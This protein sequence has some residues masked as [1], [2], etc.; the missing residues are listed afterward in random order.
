MAI[1]EMKKLSLVAMAYDQDAILN[2]LHQTNAVQITLHQD[3]EQTTAPSVDAEELQLYLASVDAAL[4]AL[5]TEIENFNKENNIKSDVL[6]DGFEV[7][8]DDFIVMGEKRAEMDEVLRRINGLV[9][10]KNTLKNEIVKALKHIQGSKIYA[11]L[12]QP[13]A[14]FVSTAKT[15]IR[16]GVVAFTALENLK[17]QLDEM[18]L[19]DYQIL[20]TQGEDAL[21][22]VMAHKSIS[23]ETDGVLSTYGF[24]DHAFDSEKSGAQ[25]Y[26]EYCDELRVKQSALTQNAQALYALKSHVHD[27][28]VY[29]EY[30]AFE[31]E[32]QLSQNKMRQ[33]DKTFFLQAY[34]PQLA[35]EQVKQAIQSVS[36][37]AYIQ[38]TE[39][40]ETDEPPTLL[41]NN[42]IVS[43]FESITNMYSAPNYREFDP[44]SVMA[45]FYSVFMGFIIGDAG[46]GLLMALIGGYLWLSNRKNP[47]GMSRLAGAFA[48]GG[49]FAIVWGM[50]FNS[51][52]GVAV[53]PTT[54]MPDP[55][56]GRCSFIGIQVPSVLIISLVVGISQLCVGYI[57]KA[58]QCFRRGQIADGI[59][60][61]IL[62]A[63]FS[64]GVAVA[65]VGLVEEMNVPV[66]GTIGGVLAGGSL[67]LA[68]LTAGRKEKFFGKFI[69]GFGAAYGVINY[70]SD[71]LSYARLY[72]LMLSGAVIAKIVSDY[73]IGFV[74]SGSV[75]LI[76]LGVIL[77]LVGHAFNL[78]MNLLGAYI[79]DARLQYVEFYGRFYEGEGELFTPLGAN[80]KYIRLSPITKE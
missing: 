75:P 80:R 56:S 24:V 47:T 53:L 32:K 31:L 42:G 28:K 36:S 38:L 14:E 64:V 67:L 63:L 68:V 16:L 21:V 70:A 27:L 71:I 1:A 20:Q 69:K 77:L 72:G 11:C 25:V 74:V 44:N 7:S 46:Y 79:H 15:K 33:T 30:L 9:D 58:V 12:Q 19:C 8:Y 4:G 18:E 45:I 59:C 34:V 55:Q 52:F 29:Y 22:L 43:N 3:V 35:E 49:V 54:V 26:Q 40:L 76:L 66:L 2:A 78:V 23:Q 5:S 39:P 10:E 62:W 6:K 50:L 13:F 61:G 37:A 51:L 17:K 41:Q 60:D 73:G 65:I 48:C 57:C